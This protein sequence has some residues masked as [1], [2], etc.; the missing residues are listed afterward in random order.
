M[1]ASEEWIDRA[2][3]LWL[4]RMDEVCGFSHGPPTHGETDVIL[5]GLTQ[6]GKTTLALRLLE[7]L[8][9]EAMGVA[10]RGGRPSGMSATPG[11]I[12]YTAVEAT[13]EPNYK[14]IE[15]QVA[16]IYRD[17]LTGYAQWKSE[18]GQG[19]PLTIMPPS[20]AIPSA[21]VN[22]PFILVDMAGF[23]GRESWAEAAADY[24]TARADYTILVVRAEYVS[25]MTG[26]QFASVMPRLINRWMHSDS[27][28]I[29]TTHSFEGNLKPEEE[30]LEWEELRTL[31]AKEIFN[32][33]AGHGLDRSQVEVFPVSFTEKPFAQ[34]MT[35]ISIREL[36]KRLS[37]GNSLTRLANAEVVRQDRAS[38]LEAQRQSL[39]RKH[40][41]ALKLQ[42]K[43]A[44]AIQ[45]AE[46]CK[47]L[48]KLQKE[49]YKLPTFKCKDFAS[50]DTYGKQDYHDTYKFAEP[51]RMLEHFEHDL[52]SFQEEVDLVMEKLAKRIDTL[53]PPETSV[54]LKKK[55]IRTKIGAQLGYSI[56]D[57][58]FKARKFL[59][60]RY[61]SERSS[62]NL[63]AAM[64]YRRRDIAA[65]AA[66]SAKTH[67]ERTETAVAKTKTKVDA[68][69]DE[70]KAGLI[71][72][73]REQAE[74]VAQVAALE[75]KFEALP[76]VPDLLDELRAQFVA[77]WNQVTRRAN[78]AQEKTVPLAQ[79]FLHHWAMREG[80]E[81]VNAHM[82]RIFRRY[83]PG[84]SP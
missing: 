72:L 1:G 74:F 16:S 58:E 32:V 15:T 5:L 57:E 81:K 52:T 25:Q 18:R 79:A 75:G 12:A 41:H 84:T 38:R 19:G 60:L 20:V 77:E 48:L 30:G 39:M 82:G 35:D 54:D 76:Q 23:D 83:A 37:R 46:E 9:P 43:V 21:A 80:L 70:L 51:K 45:D 7:A 53:M 67:L 49:G 64:Q 17:Y 69:H 6:N 68:Y 78:Q 56:Q 34:A 61:D 65:L 63:H 14:A 36:R 22:C 24:W 29:V 26:A 10:L 27:L 47:E 13:T 62:S 71:P 44:E 8:A 66:T 31:R 59:G 28:F 3:S 2:Y 73:E 4:E 33:L 42:I 50:K 55:V 11:P 40:E